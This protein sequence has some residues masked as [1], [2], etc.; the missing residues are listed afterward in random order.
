[1]KFQTGAT[2]MLQI[3]KE[4]EKIGMCP[5]LFRLQG[6]PFLVLVDKG[7]FRVLMSLTAVQFHNWGHFAGRRVK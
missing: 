7:R 3:E 2:L 6:A 5:T 4:E 1:M